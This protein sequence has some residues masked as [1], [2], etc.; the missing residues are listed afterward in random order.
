MHKSIECKAENGEIFPR[1]RELYEVSKV[2]MRTWPYP[3]GRTG[4]PWLLRWAVN[5]GENFI[6]GDVC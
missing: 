6:A 1:E 3:A 4:K 5:G 2:Q